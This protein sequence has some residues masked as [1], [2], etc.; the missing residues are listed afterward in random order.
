MPIL[1]GIP[2]FASY[3][4]EE[5]YLTNYIGSLHAALRGSEPY[6]RLL[7][8]SGAGARM[9]WMPGTW[10]ASNADMLHMEDPLFAP[11]QRVL[12]ALGMRA[13]VRICRPFGKDMEGVA[14][15]ADEE[16]TQREI[17]AS[18][19][20]GMPVIALGVLGP[21]ECCVIF[22]Y[23]D[24]G[25]RLI[26]WN[27]F[28]AEE[29]Y[30]TDKPFDAAYWYPNT[31]GYLPL[32]KDGPPPDDK[33]SVLAA[34]R[35]MVHHAHDET[36]GPYLRGF[37]AWHMMLDQL[38]HDDFSELPLTFKQAGL[39]VWANTVRGRMMVYCD[40]LCQI[41][42]RGV[43][44]PYLRTLAA[45][46]TDWAAPLGNAAIAF[47]EAAAYGGVVWQYA[48]FRSS[49]L[50]R[51]RDVRVRGILAGK[52]HRCLALEKKAIAHLESILVH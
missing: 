47:E 11:H 21:P 10:E 20:A 46:Y 33:E 13:D 30:R 16:T 25:A 52:G 7:F 22:G 40:A 15:N 5:S 14:P 39:D 35:A 36:P 19:D 28:Q 50:R 26:G 43:I 8:L 9:C 12:R 2:R 32:H 49:G 17:M 6:A 48:S 45:R 51:F 31:F 18:I 41:H 42:E 4:G 34:L 3:I 27:A 29:G 1:E 23:E 37:A 38:E 44:A 24:G